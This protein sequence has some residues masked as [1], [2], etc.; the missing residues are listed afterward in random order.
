MEIQ[1]LIQE[2]LGPKRKSLYVVSSEELY[3]LDKLVQSIQDHFLPE[4]AREFNQSVFFGRDTSLRN[5]LDLAREY[6]FFGDQKLI[7]VKDAQDIK[8]S[9]EGGGEAKDW[10][11]LS[12]YAKNPMPSTLLLILFSKK[13]DGRLSW[14]K[15]VK[16][17]GYLIEFKKISD[18]QLP[19]LLKI[20]LKDLKLDLDE[21]CQRIL[22]DSIGN[23]LATIQN[24]LEK[25][26]LN[27]TPGKK[28]TR[29]ELTRYIGISR[30]FNVFELQKAMNQKDRRQIYWISKNMAQHAKNNPLIATVGA[31]F[32]HF[33]RIWI[34]KTHAAL[35][36]DE[37]S[38]LLKLPFKSFL[39]EYRDAST[40]Y[41]LENI[42]QAI[43]ILKRIDLKSKGM[44]TRNSNESDLYLELALEFNQL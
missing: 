26:K 13:P 36:D 1:E 33:Q 9:K 8:N 43:A 10:E 28:V 34:T 2:I 35:S 20:L 6:P 7:I 39:K 40:K 19:S 4:E 23:D 32:N 14:V 42:E 12:G 22:I 27:S 15:Q 18:F 41:T 11:N 30:E 5:V 3:Y 37:L 17:L 24:E 38:K 21:E 16:E 44:Y 29:D 31:L 25:L